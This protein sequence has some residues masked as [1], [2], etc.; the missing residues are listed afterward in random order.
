MG[1]LVEAA[2][3]NF[4]EGGA[5]LAFGM[6]DRGLIDFREPFQGFPAPLAVEESQSQPVTAQCQ[7]S[8]QPAA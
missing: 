6:G 5:A 3:F 7:P 1:H 4:R 8:P 2:L